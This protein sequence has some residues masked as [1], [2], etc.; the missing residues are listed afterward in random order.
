MAKVAK[1]AKS[2]KIAKIAN[3]ISAKTYKVV[4]YFVW[5]LAIIMIIQFLAVDW[6]Y[7]KETVQVDPETH[8]EV[9]VRRTWGQHG[10][11]PLGLPESTAPP[12]HNF[13][14]ALGVDGSRMFDYSR[15]F[16]GPFGVEIE[17]GV[18]VLQ[19]STYFG[20]STT[21]MLVFRFGF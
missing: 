15:G 11:R 7:T 6:Y 2:P 16:D 18:G 9:I 13:G 4:E 21:P 10:S 3:T 5:I 14:M 19:K 1:I 17:L 8:K 12:K 20:Q